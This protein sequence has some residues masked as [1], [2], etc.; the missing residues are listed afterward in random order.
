MVSDELDAASVGATHVTVT[1]VAR[2]SEKIVFM[3]PFEWRRVRA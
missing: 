1:M 3:V 2:V